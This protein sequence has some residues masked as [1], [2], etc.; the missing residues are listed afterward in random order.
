[1][2][3]GL[4][5]HV[6]HAL[7]ERFVAMPA[8][9]DPAEEIGFRTRHLED[10]FGSECGLWSKNLRIWPETYFGAAPVRRASGFFQLAFR[11]A[12]L[13]RHSV[14]LLFA[15]DLDFHSFGQSVRDRNADA[16]QTTRSLVNF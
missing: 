4:L 2:E 1:M 7:E 12:A 8:N 6:V 10:A 9:L 15:R 16:V 13:E 14:K 3:R 11:L 5:G